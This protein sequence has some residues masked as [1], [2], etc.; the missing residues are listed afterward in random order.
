MRKNLLALLNQEITPV[1]TGFI[2]ETATSHEVI[3]LGRGG[4]DYTASLIAA[5]ICADEVFLWTD[6]DGILTA[7]PR[8]VKDAK[9]VKEITYLEAMEMSAFGA[10]SMQSRAIEPVA[11]SNIPV[12]IKNTFNPSAE[13]TV[14][15]SPERIR[16]TTYFGVKCIGSLHEVALVSISGDSISSQPGTA[17]NIFEILKEL[18]VS[19]LMISQSVSESN[20]S[21]II[22]KQDL[23]KV[24]RTL[25]ERL[26]HEEQFRRPLNLQSD[27]RYPIFAKVEYEDDVC[28]IGVLGR[29]MIGVPGIAGRVFTIVANEG[30]NIRMIAQGSSE[31]NISFV[32]KER[33]RVRALLALHNDLFLQENNNH[34]PVNEEIQ[35]ADIIVK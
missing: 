16:N 1:V 21:L 2:A 11:K 5:A 14:I 3:T 35:T 34:L 17:L 8:V 25:R 24:V 22:K 7:D 19:I 20:I 18:G 6:V 30:I 23:S 15:L 28:V 9:T 13:G 29:G 31:I 12:R 32:I 27:T 10:K 4:S 33:D 26:L